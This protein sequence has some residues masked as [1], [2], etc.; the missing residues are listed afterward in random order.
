MRSFQV[1]VHCAPFT[2]DL[3]S[4]SGLHSSIS[5]V[6]FASACLNCPPAVFSFPAAGTPAFA[7]ARVPGDFLCLLA[8]NF[9]NLQPLT[10]CSRLIYDVASAKPR[11]LENVGARYTRASM[12]Y[13]EVAPRLNFSTNFW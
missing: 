4:Q 2:H 12:L 3:F 9:S 6:G 10:C 8:K 13:S 5:F 1:Y 11:R 7:T